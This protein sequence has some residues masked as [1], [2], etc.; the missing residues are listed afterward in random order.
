MKKLFK[1]VRFWLIVILPLTFLLKYLFANCTEA[2]NFYCDYIYR[3]IS[4]LFNRIAGIFPFSLAEYLI[5]TAV[6]FGT[7]YVFFIIVSSLMSSGKRAR[8]FLIGIS[9]LL[10]I[11]SA[12]FFIFNTNCGF[13]YYRSDFEELSGMKT[14]PTNVHQLYDT[15]VYLAEN[16]AESGKKV[17]RDQNGTAVLTGNTY[18]IAAQAVN[19]LHQKYDFIYDGYAAPKGVVFSRAMSYMNITGV[20]FP[21]TFEANVNVDVPKYTIPSTMC[22]ELAHVRGFM[23]E[24]D[25]NFV[26]FLACTMADNDDL[27]YSGYMMAL[28]YSANALYA[29]DKELYAELV[30][31]Y[32]TKEMITDMQSSSEYWQQF[33]TPVA[34]TASQINDSY[35][36]ANDQDDGVKSYGKMTDLVIAYYIDL[37]KNAS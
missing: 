32:Y 21:L 20:Y 17:Q 18:Q 34:E 12:G 37:S 8:T 16:A 9:N 28:S 2:A 27:N 25:A 29:A 4:V 14:S 30:R 11:V 10:C 24:E 3:Y 23:R 33:E 13:N 6:I 15:C 19:D 1:S 31:Q 5:V 26:S 7:F 35:L 22:H 36:K